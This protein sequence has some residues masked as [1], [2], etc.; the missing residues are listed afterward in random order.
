MMEIFM[1]KKSRRVAQY[2]LK[3]LFIKEYF[4]AAHAARANHINGSNL[5]LAAEVGR[6]FKGY[7]W[8]YTE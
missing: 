2:D 7:I 4:S 8:K 1:K 6:A 5:R 3:G